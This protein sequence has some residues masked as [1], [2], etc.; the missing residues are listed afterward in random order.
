[1][2]SRPPEITSDAP[3]LAEAARKAFGLKS[4]LK[5]AD[6]QLDTNHAGF[7]WTEEELKV[8]NWASHAVCPSLLT[9]HPNY[10]TLNEK[11]RFALIAVELIS[12][13]HEGFQALAKV[14]NTDIAH[15][16]LN[17]L[18]QVSKCAVETHKVIKSANNPFITPDEDE[19]VASF[20]FTAL[21]AWHLITQ[22]RGFIQ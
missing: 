3:M 8:I 14:E 2:N 22:L 4:N 13:L 17:M 15:V 20:L 5:T 11:C 19:F 9:T 6:L 21:Q 7:K 18:E 12:I 16:E 10:K 1:M